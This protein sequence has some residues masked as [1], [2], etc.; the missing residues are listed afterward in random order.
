[1]RLYITTTRGAN[2]AG[3]AL[4][5][6]SGKKAYRAHY[7]DVDKALYQGVA[8]ALQLARGLWGVSIDGVDVEP[9]DVIDRLKA[10]LDGVRDGGGITDDD[11]VELMIEMIEDGSSDESA[12]Y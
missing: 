5:L 2:G 3:V 9:S 6:E 4:I 1:M 12:A 10:Y 7:A 8:R 11:L